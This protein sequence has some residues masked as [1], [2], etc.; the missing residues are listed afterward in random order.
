MPAPCEWPMMLILPVADC[1]ACNLCFGKNDGFDRWGRL[2]THEVGD[3]VGNPFRCK[4][5]IIHRF[6]GEVHPVE[7][8]D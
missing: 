2:G 6:V 8:K 5:G 1:P 3:G 4:L 7:G